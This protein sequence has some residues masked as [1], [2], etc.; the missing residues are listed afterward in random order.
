MFD[1]KKTLA[2]IAEQHEVRRAMKDLRKAGVGELI[3]MFE[4]ANRPSRIGTGIAFFAIG[5][6]CGAVAAILLSPRSGPEIRSD[7]ANAVGTYRTKIAE[8]VS[9]VTKR[10]GH[11]R[12]GEN[13]I[14]SA[15][16]L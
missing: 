3:E 10:N 5:A 13:G 14:P 11:A 4:L 6:T 7:I 9:R 2:W 16:G 15:T 1:V 8:G 12:R